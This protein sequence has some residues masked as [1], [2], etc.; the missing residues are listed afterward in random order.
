MVM[1]VDADIALV[2]L[3]DGLAPVEVFFQANLAGFA[4]LSAI[5]ANKP[6]KSHAPVRVD[7]LEKEAIQR[8]VENTTHDAV[9]EIGFRDAITVMEIDTLA[10]DFKNQA[11][12]DLHPERFGKKSP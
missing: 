11:P 9:A 8:E 1:A 6:G 3:E 10:L 12:V 2:A 4:Y 5:T 7:L